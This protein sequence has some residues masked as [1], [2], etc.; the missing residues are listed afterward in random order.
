MAGFDVTRLPKPVG[1][2]DEYLYAMCGLL[3]EQNRLLGQLLDRLA[4]MS[5][6]GGEVFVPR[7]GQ[8]HEI[9]I[10]AVPNTAGPIAPDDSEPAAE[11]DPEP[12]TPPATKTTPRK[13]GRPVKRATTKGA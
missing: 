12:A 9:Q 5:A 7:D 8:P 2:D 1:R 13:N 3:A 10:E 6:P 4:P 11:P